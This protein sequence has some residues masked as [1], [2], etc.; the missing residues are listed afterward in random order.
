MFMYVKLSI[1]YY[2]FT[3]DFIGSPPVLLSTPIGVLMLLYWENVTLDCSAAG[4]P[5]P[6]IVWFKDSV[7][8]LMLPPS[9]SITLVNYYKF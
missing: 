4:D 7:D 1:F 9:P 6:T 2:C 3:V 8:I 5:T